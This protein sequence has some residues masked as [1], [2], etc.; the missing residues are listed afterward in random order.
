MS[1][2]FRSLYFSSDDESKTQKKV[3]QHDELVKTANLFFGTLEEAYI[4]SYTG[5]LLQSSRCIETASREVQQVGQGSPHFFEMCKLSAFLLALLSVDSSSDTQVEHLPSLLVQTADL[6]HASFGAMS[7]ASVSA[8]IKLCLT[9][10]KKIL[11]AHEGTEELAGSWSSPSEGEEAIECSSGEF[12]SPPSSPALISSSQHQKQLLEHAVVAI[13]Q[14]LAKLLNPGIFVSDRTTLLEQATKILSVSSASL[15]P[16]LEE[17]L[18]ECAKP[19]SSNSVTLEKASALDQEKYELDLSKELQLADSDQLAR[20]LPVLKQCCTLLKELS[21]F[22]T[23]CAAAMASHQVISSNQDWSTLPDWLQ[24]LCLVSCCLSNSSSQS[25]QI[26]LIGTTTLLDL[27][28]ITSSTIPAAYWK[29][30]Q[31]PNLQNGDTPSDMFT[32]VLLPVITPTQ[33]L[34]LLNKSCVF[35]RM[36][37]QLWEGVGST[38]EFQQCAELIHQLHTLAPPTLSHVAE[39]VILLNLSQ[40]MRRNEGCS[41]AVEKFTVLWHLGRDLEP[42]R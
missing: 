8:G 11:P 9:L 35:Q 18:E 29:P 32:V 3:A 20:L 10:L 26:Y 33:L 23:Y 42:S 2:R 13:Q 12:H 16:S 22:P 36:A 34:T 4:W 6:L 21:A 38:F 31:T 15:T 37:Q 14:L 25:S 5:R 1:F 24:L 19:S 41:S 30:E 28:A 7:A 39:D 17:I 27:T 40:Q